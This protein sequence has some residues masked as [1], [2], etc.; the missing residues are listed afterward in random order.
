MTFLRNESS[1]WWVKKYTFSAKNRPGFVAKS[2]LDMFFS[3]EL[4]I[5]L[6]ILL[7]WWY[8]KKVW[9]YPAN[10][11]PGPRFPLPFLGDALSLGLDVPVGLAKLHKKYGDVVGFMMAHH[12]AISIADF[13][14]LQKTMATDE[15]SHRP[16]VPGLELYRREGEIPDI[17]SGIVFGYGHAWKKIHR[18]ALRSVHSAMS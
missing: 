1:L 8:K 9:G 15:F 17:S 12:P 18:F 10:F 7:V 5:F 16:P 3:I 14:T 11:P 13:D 6:G 2:Q 4:L